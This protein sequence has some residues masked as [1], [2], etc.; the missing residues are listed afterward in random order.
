MTKGESA[1]PMQSLGKSLTNLIESDSLS[2]D[3]VEIVI[4]TIINACETIKA[5]LGKKKCTDETDG[6]GNLIV[7]IRQTY[8]RNKK[9]IN[10]VVQ[11]VLAVV[12][13]LAAIV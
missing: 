13:M 7:R 6:I 3:A 11:L 4:T 1:D 12:S 5:R 2:D 9:N 8:N 10:L